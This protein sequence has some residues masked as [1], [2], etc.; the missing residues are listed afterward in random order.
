[1]L[2]PSQLFPY[3]LTLL[4]IPDPRSWIAA[5]LPS[6][7]VN[8]LR[9]SFLPTSPIKGLSVAAARKSLALGPDHHNHSEDQI[10]V[11]DDKSDIIKGRDLHHP[12]P[13]HLGTDKSSTQS[14]GTDA[15]MTQLHIDSDELPGMSLNPAHT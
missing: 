9:I 13:L 1:M 12:N 11:G 7:L 4:R 2:D 3:F 10:L 5:I 15:T 14:L 6:A 8:A